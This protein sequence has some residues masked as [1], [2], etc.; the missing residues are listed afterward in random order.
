MLITDEGAAAIAADPSFSGLVSIVDGDERWTYVRGLADR[1]HQV[2]VTPTTR[3]G[4]ASGSKTFTAIT[5]VGLVADGVLTMDTTARSLL[6]PDLPSIDDG[7]TVEHLLAHRSGIGDYLDEDVHSD[8][9]DHVMPVPVHRLATTEDFLA[10]LDGF[11][12]VSAPGERLAYNN[13]GY[14]VLAVLAERAAGVPFH[15]LV[16]QRVFD[17]AGM[18]GAAYLRND[19]LPGDVA[20]GYLFADGLRTNALHLPVRGSG[21]GGAQAGAEDVERLWTALTAGRLVPEAWVAEMTRPHGTT[22]SGSWHVGLGFW[23]DAGNG[24][25]Q[26]EGYDAGVSFRS[27]H[28]PAN[29]RTRTVVA[30]WT[31][32]AWPICDVLDGFGC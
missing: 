27:V 3:F 17:P 18:T 19:E 25:W 1:A 26:M 14:V 11:A 5:V 28:D 4:L 31:D 13:G 29:G 32:G 9:T 20:V 12:Q 23:L 10:V 15:D 2:P 8:V 30:N 21:D 24:W 22:E 7:V 6:G 16:Q